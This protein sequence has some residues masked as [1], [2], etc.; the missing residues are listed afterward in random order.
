MSSITRNV[1]SQI[2]GYTL[3]ELS[4]ITTQT[5]E[6]LC[7]PDDKN[8][9]VE[10]LKKHMAGELIH[11]DCTFRMAHKQGHWVWVHERGRV[12]LRSNEG[13]PL[14]MSG[15]RTD[16]TEKIRMKEEQEKLEEKYRQ[17]QT[18]ES[19]GRLAGGVAHDLNNLLSPVIGYGEML[20]DDLGPEDMARESI[21]KILHAGYS[22]RDLV[23]Q[24]LAFSRKQTISFENVDL[25]QVIKDF[26]KL[27][28][29]TIRE[30]IE[31]ELILS[32]DIEMVKADIGQIEQVVMNLAVNASDAMPD[33]GRLSIETSM[34]HLDESYAA[35]RPDVIPGESVLLVVSD[36]G[37]GMD[38]K[39]LKNIFEPFFST[40]GEKGTG[41]GLATV[42]GIV[43]QHGGNI[44]VYSES[45]RGTSFK[46]YLPATNEVDKLEK[47]I[48][49]E[50]LNLRGSETILLVED[51][52]MVRQLSQI[53]LERQG[54]NLVVASDGLEALSFIEFHNQPIHMLLTDVIMPRMNGRELHGKIVQ[55]YPD[56]K[57]LYMSGYTGNVISHHGVLDEGVKFIQ[58]PFSVE[59][60]LY[61]VREVLEGSA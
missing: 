19:V 53:I 61:K 20:M 8:N 32:P 14:R 60:L 55:H 50:T 39:I 42:Y 27:L 12:I 28:R 29:R 1:L 33:G 10:L 5:W 56:I 21:K 57:V 3:N 24:L 34:K 51:D 7:H 40:K 54:Y 26:G 4:H 58:K 35:L 48:K 36:I 41:L 43:K 59:E 45:G 49:K 2:L 46:I 37:C 22:A 15:I 47:S 38:A 23:R 9:A 6:D 13:L 16:V 30:D 52:K 31:V 17:A 11:Y 25:N 44:W 18:M